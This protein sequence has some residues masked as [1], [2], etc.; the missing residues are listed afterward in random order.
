MA[1]DLDEFL[2]QLASVHQARQSRTIRQGAVPASADV[3]PLEL[4]DSL[5]L[6]DGGGRILFVSYVVATVFLRISTSLD[7]SKISD[8]WIP[9]LLDP[10]TAKLVAH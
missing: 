10:S 5:R 8:L 3:G 9:A 2:L 7:P 4:R 1:L 6:G